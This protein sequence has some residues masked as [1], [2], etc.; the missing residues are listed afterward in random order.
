MRELAFLNK[1]IRL[2]VVD[3]TVKKEKSY[4]FKYDGGLIEFVEFLNKKKKNSKTKM[5]IIYLKNQFI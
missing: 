5:A 4:E 2:V 1:G 3:K